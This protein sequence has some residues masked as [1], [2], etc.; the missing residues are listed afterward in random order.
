[1][2]PE[3][4]VFGVVWVIFLHI[5]LRGGALWVRFCTSLLMPP[6]FLLIDTFLAYCFTR[7]VA[8]CEFF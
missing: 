3:E 8:I 5:P 4:E 2:F 1:M 7:F 6:C